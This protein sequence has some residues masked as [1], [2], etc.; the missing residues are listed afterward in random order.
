MLSGLARARCR[1]RRGRE[2]LRRSKCRLLRS[3]LRLRLVELLLHLSQLGRLLGDDLRTRR[4]RRGAYGAFLHP[5]V[6]RRGRGLL[7]HF[8]GDFFRLLD[9]TEGSDQWRTEVD[10]EAFRPRDELGRVSNLLAVLIHEHLERLHRHQRRGH[11][12]G[13]FGA[14]RVLG[15]LATVRDRLLLQV[16]LRIEAQ[17]RLAH[18]QSHELRSCWRA[19]RATRRVVRDG[20]GRVAKAAHQA[21]LLRILA[22]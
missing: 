19:R 3:E 13:L 15:E 14:V 22:F 11:F 12:P 18:R 2:L 6:A 1:R 5:S 21:V 4:R 9:R 8:W 16:D 17:R 7:L 10:A 20:L